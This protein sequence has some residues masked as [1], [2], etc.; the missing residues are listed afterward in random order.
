MM[1]AMYNFVFYPCE[2]SLTGEYQESMLALLRGFSAF[3]ELLVD[4]F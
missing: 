1:A 3:E 4:M 2:I